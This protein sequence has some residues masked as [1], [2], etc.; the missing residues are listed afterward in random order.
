MRDREIEP[1]SYVQR[2][3]L[4]S[5]P[6]PAHLLVRQASTRRGQFRGQP[7]TQSLVPTLRVCD[8][9]PTCLILGG[10]ACG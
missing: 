10:I 8:T 3:F 2:S 6:R 7:V 5:I 1:S 4:K 9:E